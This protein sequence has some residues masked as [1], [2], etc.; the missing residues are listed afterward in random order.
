MRPRR[1]DVIAGRDSRRLKVQHRD[2]VD[3]REDAAVTAQDPF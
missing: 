1:F 3:D 2:A